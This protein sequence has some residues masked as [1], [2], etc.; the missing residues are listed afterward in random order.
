MKESDF[1][2]FSLSFLFPDFLIL[3]NICHI[4]LASPCAIPTLL[5]L[6]WAS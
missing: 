2:F 5:P 4:F 3:K 6:L 1:F